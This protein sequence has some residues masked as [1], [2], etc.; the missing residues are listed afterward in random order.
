[1]RNERIKNFDK[2]EIKS[3][4]SSFFFLLVAIKFILVW[5]KMPCG[6]RAAEFSDD[7]IQ[8]HVKLT[9]IVKVFLV[10][11]FGPLSFVCHSFGFG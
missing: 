4:F 10:I 7:E 5:K 8:K 9:V 2:E 6:T 11:S 3:K 1:M